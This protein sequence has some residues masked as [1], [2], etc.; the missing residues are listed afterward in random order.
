MTMQASQSQATA[1]AG[2]QHNVRPLPPHVPAEAAGLAAKYQRL[3][4]QLTDARRERQ[5]LHPAVAQAEAAD[6]ADAA[7][8][9]AAG[10]RIPGT[11]KKDKAEQ[12]QAEVRRQVDALD[13]ACERTR[14]ELEALLGRH[15]A[16]AAVHCAKEAQAAGKR[17][18]AAL[19]DLATAESE[20]QS[21]RSQLA[22]YRSAAADRFPPAAFKHRPGS[23]GLS[24]AQLRDQI[25]R[26]ARPPAEL[27]IPADDWL[28]EP[29][30]VDAGTS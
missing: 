9:A 28:D 26:D 13:E 5:R 27:N 18:Q 22:Y 11:L 24:I 10:R 29:D 1:R 4:Q 17:A 15:A 25:G 14:A 16:D 12:A 3:A 8:A 6:R 7:A 21:W 20:L 30:H 2:G 23:S 19:D